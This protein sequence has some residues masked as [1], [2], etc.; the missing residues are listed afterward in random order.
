MVYRIL[1]VEDDAFTRSTLA[2]SLSSYGLTVVAAVDSMSGAIEIL[3]NENV[4]VL[5]V[6]IDLG[7]GPTGLDL[8]DLAVARFPGLGVV[9]LTSSQD[10]RLV[11]AS[12][13]PVPKQAV[14]LVKS[15]VTE[16][17]ILQSAIALAHEQA[18]HGHTEVNTLSQ[19]D[20]TDIQME[21]LRLV[22]QGLTNSEIAKQRFVSEKTVEYTISKI[23]AALEVEQT[24][25]VNQR[26]HIARM[27]FRMR[28]QG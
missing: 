28:G 22:A 27:Y 8:A 2:S 20:L 26:V 25:S 23:A 17:Q 3:R 21:T 19:I 11:R 14:Y 5:V 6:D 18:T 15:Q 24:S 12:L 9:L 1:I 13:P 7:P 10:P 4:D 16:I